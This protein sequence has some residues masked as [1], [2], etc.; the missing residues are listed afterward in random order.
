MFWLVMWFT[1]TRD[2]IVRESDFFEDKKL[3][4]NFVYFSCKLIV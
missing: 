4:N 2:F 3:F 1:S